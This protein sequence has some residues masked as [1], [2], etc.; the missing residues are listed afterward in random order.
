MEAIEEFW[1]S[2]LENLSKEDEPDLDEALAKLQTIDPSLSMVVKPQTI[3]MMDY[4]FGNPTWD[5]YLEK[6]FVIRYCLAISSSGDSDKFSLID[7]IVSTGEQYQLP[8]DWS[9]TK[10]VSKVPEAATNALI[11]NKPG[12]LISLATIKYV[13]QKRSHRDYH[14]ALF[15][16]VDFVNSITDQDDIDQFRN[17]VLIWLES[18]IGEYHAATAIKVITI[19]P[20]TE[21]PKFIQVYGGVEPRN[22]VYLLRDLGEFTTDRKCRLCGISEINTKLTD[23]GKLL[24]YPYLTGLTCDACF[25]LLKNFRPM[26]IK[27]RSL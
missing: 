10:F 6:M 17:G 15:M 8:D 5:K 12:S 23:H 14:L 16:D 21:I 9:V 24:E 3:C 19:L 18:V 20:E 1:E 26:Y 25:T 11:P 22:G 7:E 13:L 4:I 2:L 27:L